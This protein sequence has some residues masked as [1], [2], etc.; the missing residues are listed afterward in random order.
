MHTMH[1]SLTPLSIASTVVGV[2]EKVIGNGGRSIFSGLVHAKDDKG[3][4]VTCRSDPNRA[5]H[6]LNVRSVQFSSV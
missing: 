2:R 1:D 4:M 6:V 3:V 5:L